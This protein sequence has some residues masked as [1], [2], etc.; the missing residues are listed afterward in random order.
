MYKRICIF[1]RLQRPA[2][3]QS[4]GFPAL[5]TETGLICNDSCVIQ[6]LVRDLNKGIEFSKCSIWH[7]HYW[8]GDGSDMP[9]RRPA[10]KGRSI[11]SQH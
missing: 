2:E 10:R 5:G 4:R 11:P 6:V 3:F 8:L 1:I 9:S 7:E